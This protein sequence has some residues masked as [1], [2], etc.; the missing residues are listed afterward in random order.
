MFGLKFN[1][2]TSKTM[3]AALVGAGTILFHAYA[4]GGIDASAIGA[5]V[6]AFLVALGVRDAIA[7]NGPAATPSDAAKS[8]GV[9]L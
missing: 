2:F 6:S 1:P 4:N 9:S 5:A 8:N 3:W 7:A